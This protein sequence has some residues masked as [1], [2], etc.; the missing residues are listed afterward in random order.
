MPGHDNSLSD[1]LSHVHDE[2]VMRAARQKAERG[3]TT[4]KVLM[5]QQVFNAPAVNVGDA[6]RVSLKALRGDDAKESDKLVMPAGYKAA[7]MMLSDDEWSELCGKYKTS[8]SELRDVPLSTIYNVLVEGGDKV[9]KVEIKKVMGW[10][11][12]IVPVEVGDG[13]IAL[14][15]KAPVNSDDGAEWADPMDE[16]DEALIK[17]VV[18]LPE[19]VMVRVTSVPLMEEEK[20]QV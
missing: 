6:A 17:M 15:V 1:F 9:S 3:K 20:L 19:G 12:R 13:D 8:K 7:T 10:K 4:A 5:M 11:H 2:L 16:T 18:L 14:F